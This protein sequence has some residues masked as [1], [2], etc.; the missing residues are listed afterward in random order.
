MRENRALD[1][2]GRSSPQMTL[3]RLIPALKRR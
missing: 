2:A 1:E 3:Q